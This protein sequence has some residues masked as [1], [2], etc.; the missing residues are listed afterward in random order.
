V[1]WPQSFYAVREGKGCPICADGR[2]DDPGWGVRFFAGT[3]VDAYLKRTSIQRGYSIVTWRGRHVSEPT[4]LTEEE[5]AAG[6][7]SSSASAV[8]WSGT[9]SP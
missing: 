8:R 1:E 5:A 2:P 3:F 7:A 9:S 4:E 6:G